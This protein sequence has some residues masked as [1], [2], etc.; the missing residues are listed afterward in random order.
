M[1]LLTVRSRSHLGGEAAVETLVERENSDKPEDDIPAQRRVCTA[2]QQGKRQ[3]KQEGKLGTLFRGHEYQS[4]PR[5][6]LKNP[7]RLSQYE[8]VKHKLYIYSY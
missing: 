4:L 8:E 6:A 7:W 5:W 2:P 1:G 3:K